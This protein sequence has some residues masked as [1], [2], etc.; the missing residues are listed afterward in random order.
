MFR[1][2]AGHISVAYEKPTMVVLLARRVV[3]R[4]TAETPRGPR[5]KTSTGIEIVREVPYCAQH[6]DGAPDPELIGESV[7]REHVVDSEHTISREQ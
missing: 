2:Y 6:I 1:C 3:N 4:H 7:V 5:V